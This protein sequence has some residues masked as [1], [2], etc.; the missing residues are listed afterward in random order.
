MSNNILDIFTYEN[1]EM[2][3]NIKCFKNC[4]FLKSVNNFKEGDKVASICLTLGLL[5]WDNDSD[6]IGDESITI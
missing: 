2:I 1:V 4:T 6:L 5:I 3:K